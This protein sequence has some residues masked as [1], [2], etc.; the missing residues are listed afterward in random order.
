MNVSDTQ[1][2]VQAPAGSAPA[3]ESKPASSKEPSAPPAKPNDTFESQP[4]AKGPV[5]D[6]APRTTPATAAAA[7]AATDLPPG[8]TP[9]KMAEMAKDMDTHLSTFP[10]RDSAVLE[11]EAYAHA[12]DLVQAEYPN[13]TNAQKMDMTVA[14]SFYAVNGPEQIDN[15]SKVDSGQTQVLPMVKAIHSQDPKGDLKADTSAPGETDND[16]NTTTTLDPEMDDHT[17]GQAF[18]TNFFVAG[19]YVAGTDVVRQEV[20][21]GANVFH[22]SLDP[23]DDGKSPQ[24]Y[25]ASSAGQAIGGKALIDLRNQPDGFKYAAAAMYGMMS[26]QGTALPERF[27][28]PD[29]AQATALSTRLQATRDSE[30]FKTFFGVDSPPAKYLVEPA[31][32]VTHN[33]W[34]PTLK[35]IFAQ[36][37]RLQGKDVPL[38][39]SVK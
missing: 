31:S 14:L 23:G 12:A 32:W 35:L 17:G 20:L 9:E 22:E 18:H 5:L 33:I 11:A 26:A 38:G 15:L 21:F 7:T 25:F 16:P 3:K 13:L 27:G 39:N 6:G 34:V 19:A 4:K 8:V 30:D 24:D 28:G 10:T 36:I 1:S 37:L 2:K 29:P